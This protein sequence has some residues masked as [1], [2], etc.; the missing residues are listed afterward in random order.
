MV[1][2]LDRSEDPVDLYRAWAPARMV[3]RVRTTGGV[4]LRLLPRFSK[5]PKTEQL[6]VAKH[7]LAIYRNRASHGEYVYLELKP[8]ARTVEY[9]LHITAARP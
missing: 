9:R 7:G 8:T 5:T 2:H 3:L 4:T 6:A 1:A